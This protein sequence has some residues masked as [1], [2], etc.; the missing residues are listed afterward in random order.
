MKIRIEDLKAAFAVV[1]AVAATPVA[2]SSQFVRLDNDGAELKLTMTGLLWAESKAAM[3]NAKGKW[4]AY[5]DRRILKAFLDTTQSAEVE[6]YYKDKLI[7]K[8]DQRLE[9]APHAAISGY[10][11]W[12]PKSTFDLTDDQARALKTGVSYLPTVAGSEHMEAG[13]FSKRGLMFTDSL[14]FMAVLQ[15]AKDELFVPAAV[16]QFLA[17]NGGK[18]AADDKGVGAVLSSGFVYQPF[19][20]DLDRYPKDPSVAVV[21]E[22]R[23]SPAVAVVKA[24]DALRVLAVAQQFLL[25]KAEAAKVE[26][27]GKGLTVTVDMSVGL[28]Q[29]AIPAKA[30]PTLAAPVNW[31][32][33]KL[34]P[35]LEYAGDAELEYSKQARSSSFRFADGKRTNLLLWADV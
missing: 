22:A 27:S 32:I 15:A 28:F 13:W 29:R 10:E 33:R 18:V 31:P 24:A 34:I 7:L 1:D 16:A 12:R 9:I 35:W 8:G 17:A 4:R 25:D 20:A 3:I 21:E 23:K 14:F 19:S 30:A 26:A 5:A 11:T 2:E 6:F